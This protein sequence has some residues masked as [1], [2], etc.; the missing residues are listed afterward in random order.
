MNLFMT[1]L[2]SIVLF[3]GMSGNSYSQ[4]LPS[5]DLNTG[6][7]T[8]FARDPLTQSLCLRDG[9]SGGIFQGGQLR[10]RCSDLNFNSYSVNSFRVGVEG[11]FEGVIIDLGTAEELQ[12]RY[13]Y[14]DTVGKGQGFAS[15]RVENRK[16]MILKDY[17][18]GE[19]QEIAQSADLFK[20]STNKTE[21][22][23]VKLGHIY[24]LRISDPK[25]PSI[26]ILAKV[27]VLA[28]KPDESVT[29]RWY[30]MS[31]SKTAKL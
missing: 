12:N 15:L 30:L 28:Y 11:S 26:E 25:D 24:L 18:S 1:Y 20:P 31:D 19:L 14:S 2:V 5:G 9:G 8:L 27:L 16:A 10:N 29:I 3:V 21:A 7:A 6:I 23:P 13:G 4:Q 17:R 22:V